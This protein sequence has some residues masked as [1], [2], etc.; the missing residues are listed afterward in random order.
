MSRARTIV[1]GTC[2]LLLASTVLLPRGDGPDDAIVPSGDPAEATRGA[3]VGRTQLTPSMRAEIERV[4]ARGRAEARVA[5]RSTT[6]G[7]A[8][9]L[10]R[11]ADL[12]GQ[13]Y[14][15]HTGWT[16]LSETQARARVADELEAEVAE[17]ASRESTGDLSTLALLRRTAEL[18]PE[19]RARAERRELVQAARSVD[20]AS[21][22]QQELSTSAS[23]SGAK[24]RA[25]YPERSVVLPGKKVRAQVRTYWCGPATMQMIARG[26]QGE[27]KGQRHWARRLN[28]TTSGSS[29]WDM[30]RVV[31]QATGYDSADRA[32]PYI[33]LDISDYSFRKWL[34]LNMRH[35][36][37]YRA[38]L[39][40]HPILLKRYY[41][42]LD[43]DASGH[44]QVGRGYDKRGDK[45]AHIGYFEPWNQQRFDPSE[46]YIRRVQWRSAYKSF[47]ANKAHPQQN[48]GV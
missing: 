11:C 4:V 15:L 39:V 7:L 22:L 35:I 47:R 30:A 26:W 33:V 25:D 41:P 8:R 23:T 44:F 42:S 19:Q 27:F 45:P 16:S 1:I 24:T 10:V 40:L 17:P 38:P 48:I 46:P 43:D 3:Q 37:D 6:A 21:L 12:D 9:S 13:R 28:T 14:C 18:T 20:K 5:P 32:G 2:A 36:E 29:I 34:L 31:N